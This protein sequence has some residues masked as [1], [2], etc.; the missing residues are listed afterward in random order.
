[1]RCVSAASGAATAPI[2][3]VRFTDRWMPR[4][5]FRHRS[6]RELGCGACHA[7]A[8]ASRSSE[9]VL[10]PGKEICGRCHSSNRGVS[11]GCVDCHRYHPDEKDPFGPA[12]F[13]LP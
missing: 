2:D 9:D 3:A 6:H 11:S 5:N 7:Q 1:M 8:E 12:V 10:L 4:A 13:A